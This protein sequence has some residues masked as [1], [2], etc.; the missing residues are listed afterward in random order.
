[1]SI[2]GRRPRTDADQ[3]SRPLA[4]ISQRYEADRGS[5][6]PADEARD[7]VMQNLRPA[8]SSNLLYPLWD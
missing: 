5:G 7:M 2:L 3:L 6:P 4:L 1:M 8:Q